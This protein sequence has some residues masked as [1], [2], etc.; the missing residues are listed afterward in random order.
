VSAAPL[1][2]GGGNLETRGEPFSSLS[3][4]PREK[5]VSKP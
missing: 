5:K 3:P 2:I 1:L 4:I